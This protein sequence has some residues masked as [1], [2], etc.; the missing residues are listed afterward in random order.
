[1]HKQSSCWRKISL[2]L[3]RQI[4]IYEPSSPVHLI[5]KRKQ[6][7]GPCFLS[8]DQ[9]GTA[10]FTSLPPVVVLIREGTD[11]V[12]VIAAFIQPVSDFHS[13]RM[14]LLSGKFSVS[15]YQSDFLHTNSCSKPARDCLYSHIF[16]SRYLQSPWLFKKV[17]EQ[18]VYVKGLIFSI[19]LAFGWL[20]DLSDPGFF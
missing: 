5:C 2:T 10:T 14:L 16:K 9:N 12:S 11:P 1:M 15:S 13:H 17:R 20:F 3:S 4:Y 18:S 6:L 19:N 8:Q 7:V